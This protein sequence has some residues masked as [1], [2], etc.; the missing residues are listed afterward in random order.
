MLIVVAVSPERSDI[1]TRPVASP[2]TGASG[3]DRAEVT[4][5]P[6]VDRWLRYWL[7][8]RPVS[9]PTASTATAATRATARRPGRRA[10]VRSGGSA[11]AE[12]GAGA[13]VAGCTTG[14]AGWSGRRSRRPAA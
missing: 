7:T 3:T 6:G 10:G 1:V 5:G 2:V 4:D 14:T 12:A 8:P 11:E 9:P 13:V